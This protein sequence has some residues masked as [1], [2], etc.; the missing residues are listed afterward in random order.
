MIRHDIPLTSEHT[1]QAQCI[2]NTWLRRTTT[3]LALKLFARSASRSG[4]VVFVSKHICVK[5]GKSVRLSEAHAAEFV[6]T[7]TTIPVPKVYCA[8]VRRGICYIVMQR[9]PGCPLAWTWTERGM[10]SRHLILGQLRDMIQELRSIPR[11]SRDETSIAAVDGASIFDG[12]LPT[13]N[14]HGPFR[15]V[16]SFHLYLRSGITA[17]SN[18]LPEVRGLIEMNDQTS[19][20]VCFTHADLSS[21]N[22][23]ASGDKI[24]GI[25]DW[26]TSGWLPL[27]WEYVSTWNVNPHNQFWQQEA[28]HFLVPYSRELEMDLLRRKWFGDF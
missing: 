10:A 28:E 20:E 2:G 23:L 13:K 19:S 8:F 25:V 14:T 16:Q 1:S 11:R 22:I 12:R 18:P 6:R 3:L 21:F 15:D 24:T 26:E 7:T 27:Y 9:L 17:D 5:Y 4:S